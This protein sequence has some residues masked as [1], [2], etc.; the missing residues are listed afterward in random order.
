M[1]I[2]VLLRTA[3]TGDATITGIVSTRIYP[4]RLP[5]NP[6]Y[7]AI[8]YQRVSNSAT[9]G[10]TALRLSRWQIDC[11]AQTYEES[12]ELAAAVKAR[13][14]EYSDTTETP[15]IKQAYVVN[16]LDDEDDDAKACRT[17]VDVML[18]TTGD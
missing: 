5:Q 7:P 11:W 3:L 2:A 18:V 1:T 8:R 17:M 6:T 10:S 9:N 14:E 15:G 12:Q 16:E 4:R 13:L